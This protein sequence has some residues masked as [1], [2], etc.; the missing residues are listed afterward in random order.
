MF[1]D[2]NVAIRGGEHHIRMNI[3]STYN[4]EAIEGT[5][6]GNIPGTNADTKYVFTVDEIYFMAY[7]EE[8]TDAIK[9]GVV[10]HKFSDIDAEVRQ[11]NTSNNFQLTTKPSTYLIGYGTRANNYSSSYES[12]TNFRS[13]VN[14]TE[15]KMTNQSY[16][17][18]SKPAIV[19]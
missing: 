4:Y 17:K 9:D 11:L 5:E 3:K 10:S 16:S 1:N 2:Q 13:K 14:K 8:V 7:I 15:Q 6:T 19:M 18:T 12:P